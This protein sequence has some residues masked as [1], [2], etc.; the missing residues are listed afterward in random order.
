MICKSNNNSYHDSTC[1][2]FLYILEKDPHLNAVEMISLGVSS[3]VLLPQTLKATRFPSSPS[4]RQSHKTVECEKIIPE[5]LFQWGKN[6]RVKL[7]ILLEIKP[8]QHTL[9]KYP[10]NEDLNF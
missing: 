8:E 7:R 9:N 1:A 6:I 10:K 2:F 3:H 5:L 4:F